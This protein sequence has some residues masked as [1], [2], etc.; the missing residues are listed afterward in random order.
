EHH[1][2]YVPSCQLWISCD[3]SLRRTLMSSL[4]SIEELDRPAIYQEQRLFFAYMF[5]IML[6]PLEALMAANM[7]PRSHR[8]TP[9]IPG[10]PHEA[11][12]SRSSSS[13]GS[14]GWRLLQRSWK[15]VCQQ[16][17]SRSSRTIL[18]N[19]KACPQA[20]LLKS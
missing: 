9:W 3:Q 12:L 1:G 4:N 7:S 14:A 16:R 2:P 15:L 19:T 8:I 6:A 17:P 18:A 13:V 10:Q 5:D 20:R 11:H